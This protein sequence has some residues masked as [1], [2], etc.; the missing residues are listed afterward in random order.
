VTYLIIHIVRFTGLQRTSYVVGKGWAEIL[1]VHQHTANDP[2]NPYVTCATSP[3]KSSVALA[4]N[5][6]GVDGVG[7]KLF[8][9]T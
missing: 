4:S 2:W 3:M 6:V 5:M 7:V 8:W 1:S 9:V